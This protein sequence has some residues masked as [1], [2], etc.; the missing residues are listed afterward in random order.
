M[1]HPETSEKA[2]DVSEAIVLALGP[3]YTRDNCQA[4]ASSLQ[5][6][7]KTPPVLDNYILLKLHHS[8]S[9][10]SGQFANFD[11]HRV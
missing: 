3:L 9:P 1:K 11:M 10:T 8:N 2:R 7:P 5:G 6:V 4:W